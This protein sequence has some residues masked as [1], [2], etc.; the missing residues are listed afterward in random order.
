MGRFTQDLRK[1]LF[2]TQDD[3][4]FLTGRDQS[5]ISK[6]ERGELKE[7]RHIRESLRPLFELI[8]NGDLNSTQNPWIDDAAWKE[9]AV[10]QEKFERQLARDKAEMLKYKIQEMEATYNRALRALSIFARAL[11]D[12]NTPPEISTWINFMRPRVE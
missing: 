3:L 12:A 11:A 7:S 5:I 4:A 10:L 9:K 1:H 2:V 6:S 8:E